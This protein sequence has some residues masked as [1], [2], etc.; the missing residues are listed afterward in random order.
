M[1][2]VIPTPR[3]VIGQQLLAALD[4][5]SKVAILATEEDLEMLVQA[6]QRFAENDKESRMLEDLRRLQDEA[7]R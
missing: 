4:D 7:F 1:T 6:M 2:Q 3:E 5:K